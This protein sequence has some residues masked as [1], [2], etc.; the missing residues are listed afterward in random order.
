MLIFVQFL[1]ANNFLS[2]GLYF[3]GQFYVGSDDES[4]RLRKAS[5]IAH[6]AIPD[7]HLNF[8]DLMAHQNRRHILPASDTKVPLDTLQAH[9]AAPDDYHVLKLKTKVGGSS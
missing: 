1:Y 6:A 9:V 7:A 5:P 2:Q 3:S 8:A 4:E